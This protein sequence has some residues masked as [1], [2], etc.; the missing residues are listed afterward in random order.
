MYSLP[1][2]SVLPELRTALQQDDEAVLEA[3]PGAGKTTCVPLALLKEDWL[4]KQKIIMLEPRRLAARAAAERMAAMLGEGVGKTVGYRVRLE[5][6]ISAETRIEVVTEG[7]LTRMLQD[8]PSLEGIGLLIFD[9]FHERSL[10]ADL[11]LALAL[12][13]RD[14]FREQEC[15]KILIM[16][17]TLEGDKLSTLLGDARIIKSEGRLFPVEI[18]YGDAFI[19][20]E[21]MRFELPARIVNTVKQALV[22]ESGSLLI[23]LPG[24]AEIHSTHELLS[25]ALADQKNIIITPLYGDL[26]LQQ[27]RKAIEPA[28]AGQRKIVLATDIAE[29]SLTIEGV[30]IIIDA[31][32]HRQAVFDHSVGMSR[33][34]TRRISSASSIQRM[35]RAGRIEPGVCYRLWSEHQ[36]MQ[37]IPFTAPA[38]E[39]ADLLPLALQ[40]L[41]W[42]VNDP[43]EL[44]WLNPPSMGH[45]TTAKQLLYSLGAIESLNTSG[46]LSTHGE[47]MARL[48]LH[49]R[50]AHMLIM[51]KVHGLEKQACNLAALLS[52][53]DPLSLREADIQLRLTLFNKN[54]NIEPRLRGRIQRLK[55]QSRSFNNSINKLTDSRA[56]SKD[57]VADSS[58][59]GYLLA[60]AYPD[61]IAK[62]RNVGGTDYQM[63][64][65][66]AV[67]L[68]E[69]DPL[70][71]SEWLVVASLGG[72]QGQTIDQ[73]YLASEFDTNLF[74][75]SLSKY[76]FAEDKIDWS[77]K[78][79][80]LNAESQR[81]VGY[82]ILSRTPLK[83]IPIEK[84][85][86][87][88]L[89]MIRR[90]GLKI[91]SWNKELR[92]WQLRVMLL[93]TLDLDNAG[94][95]QWPDV[96]DN[97]L[98]ETMEAW[99]APYLNA[100]RNMKQ[101]A[102]LDL[103]SIFHNMLSWELQQKLE[104]FAP[105]R[106]R[107][108]SGSM[109]QID[110]NESPPVL[111]VRLQEMF[112]CTQTPQIANGR[113]MLKLH[114]LSPARRPIQVTQDLV[115]FWRSSYREV[116]KE[117]K[118]R[119]P[120]H[121]W[122]DDPL[123]AKP[124]AKTTRKP[125]SK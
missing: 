66:R 4:G 33:L 123:S 5:S 82:L 109:I 49:P 68:R 80:C 67:R 52:E 3:P 39:Q 73:I 45:Y 100:V 48:P 118:G 107:V 57:A 28:V 9:E 71:R 34:H 84:C 22:E 105:A 32:L 7:I 56:K 35:G 79:S 111:A 17:A 88:L 72:Q 119:Y 44:S 36:Q 10:D 23:F 58:W 95:S 54:V 6:R 19:A 115:G 120:K 20:M 98:L 65:G 21:R 83:T 25:N 89:E 96:S 110:Y 62:R 63:S 112:G 77:E 31:G 86:H 26:D 124:S 92:N 103:A 27:Q 122:P 108:P 61:R 91:L 76:V 46:K 97:Y 30:R 114:L 43:N 14:L 113:V 106:L 38:I 94:N 51:A 1:I 69:H 13:C 40:L 75:D 87:V 60:C 93:R 50:L 8:D 104:Q 29:S 121:F 99:L 41:R 74:N 37:L 18:R 2:E 11:G 42:G 90:K 125:P 12:Q 47:L 102:S 16:S 117:M 85:C 64:N 53:R 116:Q 15:L 78:Q 24:Q 81:R 59:T 101:L 55:I 70:Q